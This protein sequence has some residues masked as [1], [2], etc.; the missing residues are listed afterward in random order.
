MGTTNPAILPWRS[1]AAVAAAALG[2]HDA[3]RALAEEDLLSAR[4]FGEPVA[5]A[6]ALRARAVNTDDHD[7]AVALL[8]EACVHADH[9]PSRL[10][11][12]LCW[13]ALGRALLNSN[14][15]DDG[16]RAMHTAA[17]IAEA[18]PAPTLIASVRRDCERAASRQARA[19]TVDRRSEATTA[20]VRVLGEFTVFDCAGN[21]VTPTGV[22]GRAVRIVAAA[23]G[24]VHLE[25]LADRLWDD[26][27]D[28]ARL[29]RRLRNV[30]GRSRTD[31][32]PLL[33]R[34]DELV[35]FAPSVMIDA[36][37]FEEM[38][39]TALAAGD[40]PEAVD[41]ILTA[42]SLYSGDL[43]PTDPYEDWATLPR[44]HL[45]RC[46]LMLV[47]RGAALLSASR[48]LDIAIDL[49]ERGISH[50]PY[51]DQRFLV[52]ADLNERVGR[53]AAARSLRRQAAEVRERL[54][55]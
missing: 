11:R 22:P 18:I 26:D 55:L 9:G 6:L 10:E 20:S 29:R 5:L 40:G 8:E 34:R 33:V 39:R 2:D 32:G 17:S 23:G 15:R 31:D 16:M 45:R 19:R 51:D 1:L 37:R 48:E 46:Y 52:A 3:G 35:Q 43:L 38:A 44:E 50:D 30:L 36:H 42:V 12:A 4:H 28:A 47:D 54:G 7:A 25:E 21:D 53:V 41:A 24:R 13:H 14:R 49:L 27:A